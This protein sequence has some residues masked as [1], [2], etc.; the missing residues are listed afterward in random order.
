MEKAMNIYQRI[1]SVMKEVDYIQKENKKVNGQ[2]TFVSH[3]AV[4]GRLHEP[5]A[6][7]GIVMVPSI[8]ELQQDGNRTQVK[9]EISFVNA[10]SPE[11]KIT[12]VQYGYGIDQQDKGIGKAQ[13]YAVKYALLK[14]FGL[15]T[16]DD[17]EKD[18]IDYQPQKSVI[19][20]EIV[21]K[22]L[23]DR[24]K[25]IME[26]IGKEN[27]EL[28]PEYVS[29]IKS[30]YKTKKEEELFLELTAQEFVDAFFVWKT[31]KLKAA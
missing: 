3:D 2:Y 26:L 24:K 13:S 9:M 4:T 25:E 28:V 27:I 8:C 23:H 6:R 7:F 1:N 22:S 31:K 20:P 12:L 10:D 29:K 17:V 16:G 15:E 30:I 11:D 21:K 19:D 5:M 14:L 18:N